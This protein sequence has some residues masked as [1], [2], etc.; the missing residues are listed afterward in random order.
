MRLNGKC[1]LFI[2]TDDLTNVTL[3]GI[4]TSD[5]QQAADRPGQTLIRDRNYFGKDFERAFFET[6]IELPRPVRVAEGKRPGARLFK[7]FHQTAE[8]INQTF[9]SRLD[10]ECHGGRTFCRSD[11]PRPATRVRT[12][13]RGLA[14]RQDRTT[15]QAVLVAYDH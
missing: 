15:G 5:P 10:L 14:P 1:K 13:R 6:G 11:G 3:L 12:D 7:P 4:F 9:K 2:S 8:S